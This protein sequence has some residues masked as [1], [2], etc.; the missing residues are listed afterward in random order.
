MPSFNKIVS[1]KKKGLTSRFY[2]MSFQILSKH[3]L[4][5]NPTIKQSCNLPVVVI[6]V[7]YISDEVSH[8]K[9]AGAEGQA[10]DGIVMITDPILNNVPLRC[11][12][13]C[14]ASHIAHIYFFDSHLIITRRDFVVNNLFIEQRAS[15]TKS[16]LPVF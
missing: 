9:S 7:I 4:V 12:S 15:I 11:V 13:A 1:Y 6:F 14:L 8:Y 10:L 5:L 2:W 16:F 3:Y